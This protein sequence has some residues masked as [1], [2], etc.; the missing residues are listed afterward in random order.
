MILDWTLTLCISYM[1]LSYILYGDQH[2]V[3][4]Y[5]FNVNLIGKHI[6]K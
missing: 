4:E 6:R 3:M 1:Y 2:C 5:K